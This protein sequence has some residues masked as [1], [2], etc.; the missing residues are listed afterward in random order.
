MTVELILR[1]LSALVVTGAAV[2]LTLSAR[3]WAHQIVRPAMKY[4]A[5][6]MWITAIYRLGLAATAFPSGTE[7][8]R[9]IRLWVNIEFI[10][11][12]LG[13]VGFASATR[14]FAKKNLTIGNGGEQ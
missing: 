4:A 8:G 11:L 3:S 10:L 13:F 7:W 12:G 1:W 6:V 2:A 9:F 5:V 14:E